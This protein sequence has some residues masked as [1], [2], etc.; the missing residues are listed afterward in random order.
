M[1]VMFDDADRRQD[2]GIRDGTAGGLTRA[3]ENRVHRIVVAVRVQKV[4]HE[5]LAIGLAVL[6][7]GLPSPRR[8]AELTVETEGEALEIGSMCCWWSIWFSQFLMSGTPPGRPAGNPGRG[9]PKLPK[10][11]KAPTAGVLA[12]TNSRSNCRRSTAG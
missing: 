8:L 9:A 3:V 5:L 10:H 2:R 7:V 12:V 4:A 1:F 11:G 6:V